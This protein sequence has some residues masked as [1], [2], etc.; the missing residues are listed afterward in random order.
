MI[1][2]TEKQGTGSANVKP[3]AGPWIWS[4]HLQG[5]MVLTTKNGGDIL[6][7]AAERVRDHDIIKWGWNPSEADARLI[8]AAPA[9]RDALAVLLK[10]SL[11]GNE[12]VSPSLE[13]I[14]HAEAALRAAGGK[15]A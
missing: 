14:A 10:A 7:C 9:L 3:T 12:V 1:E 13:A 2:P 8:V 4:T 15:G 6:A 11:R 5:L